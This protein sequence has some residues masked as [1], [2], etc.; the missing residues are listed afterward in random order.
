MVTLPYCFTIATEGVLRPGESPPMGEG[1]LTYL[2]SVTAVINK[3]LNV[4]SVGNEGDKPGGAC[5]TTLT[6]LTGQP[7]A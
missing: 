6:T 2:C 1:W 4:S 7:A 5:V 3:V